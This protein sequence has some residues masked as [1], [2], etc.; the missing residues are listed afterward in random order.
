MIKLSKQQIVQYLESKFDVVNAADNEKRIDCPFCSDSKK[1]LYVNVSKGV[2]HCHKCGYSSSFIALVEKIEERPIKNLHSLFSEI[3]TRIENFSERVKA[4][5]QKKKKL[6]TNRNFARFPQGYSRLNLKSL[7][8][9]G[10]L[11]ADYL[12]SRGFDDDKIV[13]YKL[14][15]CTKGR[16]AG[17]VI[18]PVFEKDRLVYYIGRS[19]SSSGKKVLNPSKE[20]CGGASQFLFNYDLAKDYDE[21]ILCE[22][23]FDAITIGDDAVAFFGK[24]MSDAQLQKILLL[25]KDKKFVVCL[26]GDAK[27][28]SLK[29]ARKL[30]SCRK[31]RVAILPDKEDPNSLGEVDIRKHISR[32][33]V[34][35]LKFEVSERMTVSDKRG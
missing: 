33:A 5:L 31:V 16:F 7:S 18:I 12:H 24:E 23:A 25:G 30:S 20:E 1:H 6:E 35:N 21:I 10:K 11:A 3:S 34:Y 17:R 4:G 22:G 19:I 29:I 28:F 14:G 13:K 2:V 27:K 9:F 32:A 15:Y 26:D 8:W